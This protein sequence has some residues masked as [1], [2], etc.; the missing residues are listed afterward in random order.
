MIDAD[1]VVVRPRFVA[2]SSLLRG[3]GIAAVPAPM[4]MGEMIE[5]DARGATSVPGVYAAGN[6]ADVSHQVLQAAAEGSRIAAVINAELAHE[7]ATLALEALAGDGAGDWDR[8][9]AAEAQRWSGQPNQTLLVEMEDVTPGSALEVGC[10]EGADAIWLARRG[11]KVTAVDIS[12]VALDRA[13]RVAADIGVEIAWVRAD[14]A[15][16]PPAQG[17]Y[18]LVSVHYP[19]LRHAVGDGAIHALVEAVAPGGTLLVVGH[20]FA[21]AGHH[22]HHGFDPADY[23]QPPDVARLLDGS[24]WTIEVQESR[25]RIRPPGSESPDVPD[26]VLRARRA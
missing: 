9:Y 21:G 13:R 5:T 10:G 6:V 20:D 16:E 23:V 24:T 2:R 22:R 14:V 4:G 3:L 19:A 25:P 15:V 26:L 17:R 7:D 11:W 1:A 18:D 12:D 8:R